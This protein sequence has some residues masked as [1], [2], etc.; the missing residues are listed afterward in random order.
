MVK[1]DTLIN[2]TF[3]R[4]R[5]TY[6][7]VWWDKA[8]TDE[9]LNDIVS[10]CEEAELEDA[11]TVGAESI[12]SI[13]QIR[14]SKVKFFNREAKTDFIFTTFN[15]VAKSL[16]DQFYNFNLNGYEYFQYTVYDGDRDA[17]EQGKYSWHMD[18]IMNNNVGDSA[19]KET[20]KLT[21]VL[22]L[23]EPGVDFT[24]GEFQLNPGNQDN[25]ITVDLPR[26]RIV[27]F[28]SWM[29]HQ[30]KPVIEGIRKSIVIWVEGPKFI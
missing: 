3:E 29:I 22:L 14:R 4:R 23:S 6:S 19:S 11:T 28:P 2:N 15:F 13:K 18:L 25:P 26:G 16:N 21:L 7:H 30:V 5:I 12:E 1:Y 8:F 24:G 9:Q 27:A 20:R 10:I 17:L